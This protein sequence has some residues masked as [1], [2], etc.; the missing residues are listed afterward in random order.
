MNLRIRRPNPED[1]DENGIPRDFAAVMAYFNRGLESDAFPFIPRRTPITPDEIRER[2]LP[3]L[4]ANIS[5]VVESDGKVVGSATVFFDTSSTDYAEAEQRQPGEIGLTVDPE[6]N[7]AEVATELIKQIELELAIKG[8]QATMHTDADF[9]VEVDLMR[10]LGYEG[11]P[12]ESY[13]RYVEGGLSGR[14][15]EYNLP[16]QESVEAVDSLKGKT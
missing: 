4:E 8:R 7:Y 16:K 13:P 11:T 9:H 12:I 2:W 3:S 1:L 6:Q 14:V 15:M 5:Y 10:S